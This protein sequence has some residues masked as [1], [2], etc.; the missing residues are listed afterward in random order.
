M[1]VSSSTS[2]TQLRDRVLDVL[3][4]HLTAPVL[5]VERLE[6]EPAEVDRLARRVLDAML[7]RPFR[8]GVL[9]GR[10]TYDGLLLRVR[11]KVAEGLPVRVTIGYGPLKN[12]NAVSY[13]RADW[14]EFFA[15]S[16]LVALHEKVR[17]LYPPG[18]R[19]QIVFD[20]STLAMANSADRRL[21]RSY[22]GSVRALIAAMGLGRLIPSTMRQSRFAF[23]F[24]FGPYQIARWRVRR[25]ER[26]PEN[27]EQIQK[28][29]LYA[30]RNL[31]FP[32]GA[33]A[34]ERERRAETASH[35]YRVYWEVLQLF[36]LTRRKSS[37]LA[38]Y[39]DGYQHHIREPLALH[40]TTLGKGN[41]TQ[42]WQG[43]GVLLDNGFG[44][45]VPMVLTA[46]RRESH[47]LTT[48]DDLD[49]LP[50][51]QFEQIQVAR[52]WEDDPSSGRGDE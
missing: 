12:Q 23:L 8:V 17:A 30:L 5:N 13:S 36:G 46:S 19:Y 2:T 25:W 16:H 14:A 26:R 3:R 15:L 37:V 28:M 7:T 44:R 41:V 43:A 20:D 10:E 40:L 50:L 35:N 38:M 49:V 4:T 24:P 45:L 27:R 29:T 9:P 52:R 21:M 47:D 33:S 39:L 34:A 48:V 31:S 1:S 42:P 32:P 51:P 18:V 22:I 11:R 6:V